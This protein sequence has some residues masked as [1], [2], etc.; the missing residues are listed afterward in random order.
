MSPLTYSERWDIRSIFDVSADS[1]NIQDHLNS[2]NQE[3]A[4]LERQVDN[5]EPLNSDRG[6]LKETI[7]MVERLKEYVSQ[8][9][10][11]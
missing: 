3:V 2:I 1:C 11:S 4:E 8:L 6:Q 10:S 5:L 7:Q 9:S